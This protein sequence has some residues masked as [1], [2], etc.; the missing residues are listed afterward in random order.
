[1][2]V[3]LITPK[4]YFLRRSIS[5][6]SSMGS[7]M[8]QPDDEASVEGAANDGDSVEKSPDEIALE[9]S[10]VS[11]NGSTQN[12]SSNS[13][14][15]RSDNSTSMI[16]MFQQTSAN[17][18]RPPCRSCGYWCNCP[19][20]NQTHPVSS[21]PPPITGGTR[22]SRSPDAADERPNKI[23]RQS[24]PTFLR[25]ESAADRERIMNEQE[26][27]YYCSLIAD[28]E[29]AELKAK[30]AAEEERKRREEKEKKEKAA[31]NVPQEPQAG[32]SGL[33]ILQICLPSG[34]SISRRFR[35]TDTAFVLHQFVM[36]QEDA[37]LD[38]HISRYPNQVLPTG[39][40]EDSTTLEQLGLGKREIVL[41]EEM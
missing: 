29:K 41:V 36:S 27:A 34:R 12:A 30:Q 4:K 32:E 26:V 18:S 21:E 10:L 11:T 16:G 14:T 13:P 7:E 1:M 38:F 39:T 2:E 20:N 19:L 31:E 24:S 28:R 17:N 8:S 33:I 5:V 3:E 15:R 40:L 9:R 25:A 37:P 22:R 6:H 35:A 23:P